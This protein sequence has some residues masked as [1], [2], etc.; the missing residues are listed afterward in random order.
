MCKSTIACAEPKKLA[1]YDPAP[2]SQSRTG[3]QLRQQTLTLSGVSV[4]VRHERRQRLWH[5]S[6]SDTGGVAFNALT[7]TVSHVEAVAQ[8]SR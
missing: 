5:S 7:G 3:R 2:P 8:A 1:A 4:Q 6:K